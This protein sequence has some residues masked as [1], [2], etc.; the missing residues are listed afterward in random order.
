MWGS[1]HS[2]SLFVTCDMIIPVWEEAN[3]MITSYIGK[4]YKLS[5]RDKI[6]GIQKSEYGFD[7]E[8]RKRVN[9]LILVCKSVISKFK[10]DKSGNVKVL[11]EN[12]VFYRGLL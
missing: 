3:K 10:Y 1:G 8:S 4:P 2:C 11:L 7:R 5:E 12:Q 6:I 9:H